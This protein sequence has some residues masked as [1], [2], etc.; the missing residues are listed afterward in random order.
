MSDEG[1]RPEA[2]GAAKATDKGTKPSAQQAKPNAKQKPN[3]QAKQKPNQQAKQKQNPQ[4]KQKPNPQVKPAQPAPPPAQPAPPPVQPTVGPARVRRRHWFLV[5]SFLLLVVAPSAL[6]AWYLWDRAEDQY[7]SVSGFTVRQ[8]EGG[9]ASEL[10]GGLA[11]LTGSSGSSDGD[12]LFEFLQSPAVVQGVEASVGLREHYAVH[13]EKDPVFSLWPD[14]SNEALDWY[15][16]R[17]V[18][19]SYDRASGLTEMRVLAFSPDKAQEIARE[20]VRQSQDMINALNTQAREDAMRYARE[21]LD[22]AV[23]RLKQTR[24]AMVEFRSRTQIVDPEADI[25][26]RMGVVN[27]LQLKLAEALIE[28]DLLLEGV[29]AT[30]PRLVQ[31]E[32]RIEVIRDR[33]RQE[34][35]SVASGTSGGTDSDTAYPQLLAEFEGLIVEREFAEESYRAALAALDLARAKAQRQSRYLATYIAP[36]LAQTSEFPRREMIQGLLMLF[37]VL[38]WSVLVLIYYSI[39]DRG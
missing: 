21:D 28:Y 27:N 12:I 25:Q 6:A 4:A 33:I 20:I 5:F 39:R 8:E 31:A 1:K 11:A 29:A 34:R 16:Q 9:G 13:W 17:I 22:E 36:T 18:R 15:W 35:Q 3:P 38:S 19:V 23:A 26:G 32:Q 24:E 10:L 7:S 37:L 14:A 30:D 2:T